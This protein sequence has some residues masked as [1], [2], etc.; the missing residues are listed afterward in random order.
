MPEIEFP[1]AEY[2][3]PVADLIVFPAVLDDG[4]K[5]SCAVEV[6]ALQQSLLVDQGD[7]LP[8]FRA[9]RPVLESVAARLI[10]QGRFEH[11]GGILIAAAD[12]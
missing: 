5:L 12:L 1:P 6:E 7:P 10:A 3:D 2:L 11:N 9:T 4:R 8:A